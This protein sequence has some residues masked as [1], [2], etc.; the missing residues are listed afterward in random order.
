MLGS[1]FLMKSGLCF[2]AMSSSTPPC[3]EPRPSAISLVMAF[4][5]TS[6]VSNSGGR[7]F[8]LRSPFTHAS[9]SAS[10]SAKSP[11]NMSGM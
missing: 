7:R 5:T 2:E 6:R 3:S 11:L 8:F 10:V 9:D 1:F 4:A